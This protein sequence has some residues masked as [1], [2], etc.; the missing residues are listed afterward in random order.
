MRGKKRLLWLLMVVIIV[1]VFTRVETVF[2]ATTKV[3]VDPSISRAMP[4]ESFTV[5]VKVSDVDDLYSFQVNMS[6]DPTI[7]EYVNVTEG[8]F[9]EQQPGGT[10][11]MPP[12]VEEGWVMFM[13]STVEQYAGVDGDGT[14][15]TVEFNV[16]T[17]GGCEL[18]ID[19]TF[20]LVNDRPYEEQSL[21]GTKLMEMAPI[22][23]GYQPRNI[24]FTSVNGF[25][26]NLEF[27]PEASF[28]YS[29]TRPKIGETVT[30]NASASYDRDG[31]IVNYGWDFGDGTTGAGEIVTHQYAAAGT[32]P[33]N[34]TVTDDTAINATKTLDITVRFT[35]DIAVT[36]VE[37]SKIEVTAGESISINATVL[38]LGTV[39]ETF[40]VVAYYGDTEI[41]EKP[42][43][44]LRPDAEVTLTFNW[45][46]T[47]VAKG[48]YQISAVATDVEGEENP[49]DN[50]YVDGTIAVKR[51]GSGLPIT[52]V[53]SVVIVVAVLGVGIFLYLRRRSASPPS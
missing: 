11:T 22:A 42:V 52:L 4:G 47:G 31:T 49:D 46:T 16:L 2:S 48:T 10:H 33:V 28:T 14:L 13:W 35:H 50:T 36:N 20:V 26:T 9:L 25:F 43:T 51:S 1:T 12:R 44:D 19:N 15:A 30:F 41:G 27:P 6:F 7:L 37:V 24:P 5:D 17:M 39:N 23:G 8:D 34:L 29:P 32:Y 40:T 53:I 3:Y 45:D 18:N 38:N 21:T